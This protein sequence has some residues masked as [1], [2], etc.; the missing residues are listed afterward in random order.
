MFI[1]AKTVDNSGNFKLKWTKT[2]MI[3]NL[4]TN[5]KREQST[6]KAP[7]ILMSV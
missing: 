2:Q 6:V 1:Q 3:S 4:M 5:Q 7:G